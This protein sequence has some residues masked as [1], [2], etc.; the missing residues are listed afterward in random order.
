MPG[1]RRAPG[2]RPHARK[3]A[4][5]DKPISLIL[6]I[7]KPLT[8][9]IN[10]VQALHLLGYGLISHHEAGGEAIV[11]LAHNTGQRLEAVKEI[12]NEMLG[13]KQRSGL[14]RRAS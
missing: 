5:R 13:E 9:A 10:F 12:W 4:R 1:M 7:E 6:G 11:A 8:D 14:R 3:T 2:T